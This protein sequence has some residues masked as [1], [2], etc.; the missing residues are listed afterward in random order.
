MRNRTVFFF[1]TA[2]TYLN[3]NGIGNSVILLT[4]I[5]LFDLLI[6]FCTNFIFFV[7]LIKKTT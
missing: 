1:F 2:L 3:W 5:C 6:L 7:S 4:V